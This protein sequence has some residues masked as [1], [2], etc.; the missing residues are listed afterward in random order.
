MNF[1]V[2]VNFKNNIFLKKA[3]KPKKDIMMGCKIYIINSQKIMRT[4]FEVEVILKNNIFKK[5]Y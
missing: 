5:R 4:N 3:L 1:E 2:E